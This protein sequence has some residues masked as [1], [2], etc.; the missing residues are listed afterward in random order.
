MSR[1]RRSIDATKSKILDDLRAWNAAHEIPIM[2]VTHSPEEAFAVGER[3]VV[4][5]G[6]R[7]LAQGIRNMSSLRRA[8]KPSRK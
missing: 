1:W 6:G 4:L 8:T 5:E 2:Y 7:I 3:V